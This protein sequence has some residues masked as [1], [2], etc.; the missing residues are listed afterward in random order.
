MSIRVCI[1]D[2]ELPAIQ[3]LSNFVERTPGLQLVAAETES[4]IA[5]EKISNGIIKA[6]VTFL[7]IQMP[8]V[9]GIRMAP[10]IMDKC[11]IVFSTAHG[12]FAQEAFDLNA[13]DYLKKVFDY[14]RFLQAVNKIKLAMAMRTAH[15]PT[16][17]KI[18]LAKKG[19]HAI[20]NEEDIVSIESQN[21]Y[22]IFKTFE[23]DYKSPDFTLEKTLQILSPDYF[24]QVHRSF[25]I[26]MKK[27]KKVINKTVMMNN[28]YVVPIG[29]SFEKEFFERFHSRT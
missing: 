24:M 22:V 8:V 20:I 6:D 27:I 9:T 7:D 23:E 25:I 4:A 5:M 13:V 15:V 19:V 11:L 1:V 16:Q 14:P 26:N 17:F 21:G 3:L 28:D 2:D 10:I 29:E 18:K 12:K